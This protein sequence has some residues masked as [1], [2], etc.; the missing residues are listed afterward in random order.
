MVMF[1]D[2][3]STSSITLALNPKLEVI[4]TGI[5]LGLI[6]HI[7]F[8]CRATY[9]SLGISRPRQSE[10]CHDPL[11]LAERLAKKD[12]QSAQSIRR[13]RRGVSSLHE[14]LTEEHTSIDLAGEGES[15]AVDGFP[16]VSA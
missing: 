14:F 4:L 3:I 6:K 15:Q 2:C 9:P 8:L 16:R 5:I 7:F 1:L 10:E 12:F 13:W 11:S